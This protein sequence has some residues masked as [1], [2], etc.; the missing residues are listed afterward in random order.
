MMIS[1][2]VWYTLLPDDT[3][4]SDIGSTA[5]IAMIAGLFSMLAAGIGRFIDYSSVETVES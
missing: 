3:E 4:F 5:I 1:V 2:I